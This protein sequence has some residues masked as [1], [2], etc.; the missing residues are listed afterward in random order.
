MSERLRINEIFFSIQGESTWAGCPC[1]FVRLTGCNLRCH[2][3]DT[4]YAF[5]EGHQLPIDEV[6]E[7]VRAYGCNLVEVT[8]G[9]PLLQKGIHRLFEL[10]LNHGFTVLVETSGE[11][12]LS[13]IDPRIIKIVDLKCPSSGECARN[14]MSNL[15]YVS[16]RDELKFVIGE[17]CD[18]EW[19]CE[20][21]RRYQLSQLVRAVLMSPVFGSLSPADLANWILQERLP[22]R[23]QLQMHKHIWPPDMRGV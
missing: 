2:W 7:R 21:I 4:K 16:N 11:R 15:E 20:I 19:A 3:C 12:D 23:M 9:E 10:L 1:V 6:V 13:E 8:G 22:V 14:R 17:R 18:F 5:Y